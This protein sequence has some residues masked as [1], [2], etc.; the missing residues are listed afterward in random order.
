MCVWNGAY[1]HIQLSSGYLNEK[2]LVAG[3]VGCLV[4]SPG[5]PVNT[6]PGKHFGFCWRVRNSHCDNT[7]YPIHPQHIIL[8]YIVYVIINLQDPLIL[9]NWISLDAVLRFVDNQ[10]TRINTIRNI[11]KI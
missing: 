10:N 4:G 3:L 11:I 8:C 1:I 7:P 2:W 6:P 9:N 5:A